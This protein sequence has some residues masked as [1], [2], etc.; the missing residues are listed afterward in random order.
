M[1]CA[2]KKGDEKAKTNLLKLLTP[3]L[4]TLAESVHKDSPDVGSVDDL[5]QTG[6]VA[7]LEHLDTFEP[8]KNIPF[9]AYARH[10]IL[11]AMLK[12]HFLARSLVPTKNRKV[13]KAY[14]HMAR[15]EKNLPVTECAHHFTQD[16]GEIFLSKKLNITRAH[17]S[18]AAQLRYK[19]DTRFKTS[20]AAEICVAP[21]MPSARKALLLAIT[22]SLRS[23]PNKRDRKIISTFLIRSITETIKNK[24]IEGS[25]FSDCAEQYNL[26]DTRVRQIVRAGKADIQRRLAAQGLDAT[27]VMELN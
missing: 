21:E 19:K 2:L 4:K 17:A 13:Q 7:L 26:T 14:Y 6:M 22:R 9:V 16:D 18:K 10:G 1:R 8:E 27:T 12:D 3:T 20:D 24:E 11:G 5:L 15:T 25:F 23:I